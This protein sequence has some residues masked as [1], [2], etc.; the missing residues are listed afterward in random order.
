MQLLSLKEAVSKLATSM[1]VLNEETQIESVEDLKE[2]I[3]ALS[4]DIKMTLTLRHYSRKIRK[5][6]TCNTAAYSGIRIISS[7]YSQWYLQEY[8]NIQKWNSYLLD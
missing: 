2:P 3:P 6:C 1:C 7:L 5:N 4:T 8:G